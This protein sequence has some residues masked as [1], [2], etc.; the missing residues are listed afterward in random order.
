M[1]TALTPQENREEFIE[2]LCRVNPKFST[3]Q[4]EWHGVF[5]ATLLVFRPCAK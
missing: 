4:G 2:A 3:P 1:P 5:S